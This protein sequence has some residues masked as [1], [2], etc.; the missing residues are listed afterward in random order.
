MPFDHENKM[1]TIYRSV[2]HFGEARKCAYK[3]SNEGLPIVAMN[4]PISSLFA[5][6]NMLLW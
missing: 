6:Y 3:Q 1:E 4:L 2:W 5:L